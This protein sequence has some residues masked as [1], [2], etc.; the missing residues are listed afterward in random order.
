MTRQVEVHEAAWCR[1]DDIAPGF[2]RCRL[3]FDTHAAVE[4]YRTQVGV[5]SKGFHPIRYLDHQLPRRN[6]DQG[7]RIFPLRVFDLHQDGQHIRGCLTG[8]GLGNA[9]DIVAGEDLRYGLLLDG[10]GRFPSLVG[11]R[12]QQLLVE[13]EIGKGGHGWNWLQR[14][15]K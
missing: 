10:C 5:L 6:E 3:R 9:Q 13:F 15:Q 12:R 14:T 4:R 2:K 7:T 11:D 8:T 1:D